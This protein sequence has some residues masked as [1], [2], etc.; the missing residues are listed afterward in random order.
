[1]AGERG[2]V[3]QE[4]EL[5]RSYCYG[6]FKYDE[7]RELLEKNHDINMSI[8][9]LKRQVKAYGRKRKKPEYDVNEVREKIRGLLDGPGCSG[10]YRTVWHTLEMQGI[11][12]PRK[13]LQEIL[14]DVDPD[15]TAERKAHR[16]QW[17]TYHNRGPNDVW[18]CDGYDKLKPFGFPIH[19]C[20][21]GW[22][23]K[24]LWLHVT[25]SNNSPHNIADYY[26]DAVQH[27]G[28]CPQKLVTDLGT[29]NGIVASIQSFFRDDVESHRYVP[30]PRNQRIEGWWSYFRKSRTNWWMNFF[31][32]LEERGVFNQAIE[33]QSECLWFCFASLLQIDIDQ[34]KEHWNTH[35][36]RRSRHD[37]VSGRPDSLYYLA[38]SNGGV[39]NLLLPVPENEMAYARLHIVG[40]TVENN[41]QDYFNYVMS[42]CQLNLPE[43]WREGLSLYE[44]LLDHAHNGF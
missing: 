8:A 16:L 5:I 14:K 26:L 23:K 40:T 4:E 42:T 10:G 2:N 17:R 39:S 15:G 9:T 7:I 18:H 41:Y 44:T 33:L 3:S 38:E 21:D 24:M 43:N 1:M 32:D 27:F 19:G 22:S 13:I 35:Y 12:V 20:I 25:R 34:V 6:G 37:T 30:S 29:E 31:K 28:G 36:I 11:R